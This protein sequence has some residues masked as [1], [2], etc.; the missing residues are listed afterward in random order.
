MLFNSEY[1]F[2][3]SKL[4]SDLLKICTN[5]PSTHELNWYLKPN[6][7]KI[8]LNATNAHTRVY[9]TQ[10]HAQV[11]VEHN[12]SMNKISKKPTNNAPQRQWCLEQTVTFRPI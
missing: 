4:S 7:N 10:Y 2:V 9:L 6:A 8:N 3:I 1:Y 11:R 12:Y 5:S